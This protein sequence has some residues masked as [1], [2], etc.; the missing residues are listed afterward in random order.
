MCIVV[1][2]FVFF[3]LSNAF[4]QEP[5]RLAATTSACETGILD[6]IIAPFEEKFNA[7]VHLIA[8][9]TGK[10]IALAKNGDAD[11]ILVHSKEAED[12]FIA[13]GYG[14]NRHSVMNNDFII[15]GPADDPAGIS[16][17]KDVQEALK[18]IFNDKCAFVSRGDDSGTDKKEKSLW[19]VSGLKPRGSWYLEAGQGMSGTLRMA[20]EKNAYLLID[21]ATYLVNQETTALNQLF[22]GGKEL[23]NPYSVIAVNPKKHRHVKYNLALGFIAWATSPECREMINNYRVKGKQ[24]FHARG[25]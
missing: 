24:L 3:A 18:K 17:A 8:V 22:A 25:L 1:F 16:G 19:T 4:A 7:Q 10:A 12:K 13:D 20:D 14:M 23:A 21:S 6:H 5:L 9:G 2:L 11:L 15:A